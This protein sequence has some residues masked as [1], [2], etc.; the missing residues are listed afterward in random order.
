[1]SHN[2]N[3][4]ISDLSVISFQ[5][6]ILLLFFTLYLQHENVK[7]CLQV[8]QTHSV[9]GLEKITATDISNGRLK[10]VLSLFFALS[11]Y[12]Q[13]TKQ[14]IANQRSVSSPS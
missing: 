1:M 9:G 3:R 11:R 14:K 4:S 2:V 8:L 7:H 12:K 10:A 5:L 13:E 6:I